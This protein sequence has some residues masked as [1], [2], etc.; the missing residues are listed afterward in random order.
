MQQ[1]EI[2]QKIAEF[3]IKRGGI[4]AERFDPDAEIFASGEIDSLTILELTIFIEDNFGI[5]IDEERVA[6]LKSIGTMA[7]RISIETSASGEIR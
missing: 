4:K 7:D 5:E 1:H 3:L 6:Q 2:A